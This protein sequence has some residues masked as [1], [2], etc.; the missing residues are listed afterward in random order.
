MNTPIT[1]RD[2]EP[3]VAIQNQVETCAERLAR[4]FGTLTSCRVTIERTNNHHRH[5]DVFQV[6]VDLHVPQANLIAEK[7]SGETD[8]LYATIDVAFEDLRRRLQ[9]HY[10]R[11]ASRLRRIHD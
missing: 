7:T 6:R 4:Q 5:G 10:D 9:Q 2:V 11:G 8:D 1:F 3:S